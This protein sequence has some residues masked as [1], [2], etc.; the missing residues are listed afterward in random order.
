MALAAKTHVKIS[1]DSSGSLDKTLL[2]QRDLLMSVV[3][4]IH[5]EEKKREEE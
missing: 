2:L 4:G 1:K 3:C 5:E